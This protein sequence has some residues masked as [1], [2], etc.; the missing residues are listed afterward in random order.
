V[1]ALV[2]ESNRV[3]GYSGQDSGR[4]AGKG[5]CHARCVLPFVWTKA[6]SG[7]VWFAARAGAGGAGSAR[8]TLVVSVLVR[9]GD[10]VAGVLGEPDVSNWLAR[11][12]RMLVVVRAR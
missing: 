2:A 7:C 10:R 1:P 5:V 6:W 8:L 12:P 9:F 3:P 4:G 11:G